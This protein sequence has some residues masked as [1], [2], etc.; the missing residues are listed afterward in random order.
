M[1]ESSNCV[2]HAHLPKEWEV[3]VTSAGANPTLGLEAFAQQF[4]AQ[5][6]NAGPPSSEHAIHFCLALG[7]QAAYQLEPGAI[8]FEW[9]QATK[10]VDLWISPLRIGYRGQVPKAD[11]QR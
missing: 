9:P 7:F 5:I 3:G 1:V 2:P 4:S 10:R 11:S 6:D 8:V